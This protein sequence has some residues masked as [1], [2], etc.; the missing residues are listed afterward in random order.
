M[1]K[2]YLIILALATVSCSKVE[3]RIDDYSGTYERN[4]S[5]AES[6][7]AVLA[8]KLV[9]DYLIALEAALLYDSYGYYTGSLGQSDYD[10]NGKS[11]RT[12]GVTWTVDAKKKVAGLKITCKGG[13]TWELSREGEYSYDSAERDKDYVTVCNMTAVMQD[14]VSSGHYNWK[15]TLTGSRTEREGYLCRFE[16]SP[17]LELICDQARDNSWDNCY[18]AVTMLILKGTEKVDMARMDY[19]GKNTTFLR[20]L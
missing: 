13:D 14:E 19:N 18:G 2:I 7:M 9:P 6:Y 16:S 5:V 4:T 11:I 3:G 1:K 12:E 17:S 15:V 20:G 10:S 8:S